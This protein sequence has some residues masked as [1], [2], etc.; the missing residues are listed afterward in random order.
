[1]PE[2]YNQVLQARTAITN[3]NT[4]TEVAVPIGARYPLLSMELTTAS[5]RVSTSNALNPTSQGFPIP[6][7]GF[8]Q[9]E[10]VNTDTLVL[11]VSVSAAT[12]AIMIYTKD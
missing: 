12:T 5:F 1:M 8:Y 6:A 2:S 9:H 10:G 7:K 4:W 3:P 11:Y